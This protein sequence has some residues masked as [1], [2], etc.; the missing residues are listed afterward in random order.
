MKKL[1]SLLTISIFL[2]LPTEAR[3]YDLSVPLEG[4]SIVSDQLQFQMATEL[5]SDMTKVMPSCTEI[6]IEDTQIVHYP[7]DTKTKNGRYLKGYWKEIWTINACNTK[8]QMPITFRIKKNK[9]K[10]EY[11]N[12]IDKTMFP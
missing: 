2:I 7:Y 8:V 1:I 12:K 4:N 6:C 10:Y 5:I 3:I 9:I 11:Q